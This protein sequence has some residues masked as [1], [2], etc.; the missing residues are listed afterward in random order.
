MKIFITGS[1]GYV[2]SELIKQLSSKHEIVTFDLKQNQDILNF[3]QLEDAMK[4]CDIVIH[5]A[6]I[7][8]PDETKSFQDY[9]DLNCKATLNVAQASIKNKVKKLIYSSSTG[10]YGVENG[11]PYIKSIKESNLIISQ[12]VDINDLTCR[13]CDIGYSTSKVITE[14]IPKN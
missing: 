1:S 2:G 12:H 10:Y 7:R 6:A 3:K 11:I 9:F 5:L 13:D 14:Q 4:N 8:G